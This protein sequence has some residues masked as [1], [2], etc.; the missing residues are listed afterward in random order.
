MNYSTNYTLIG[1]FTSPY[2]R[3]IRL[4]L[5]NLGTYEFKSINYLEQKDGEYL[6][7]IN[8]I[9]QI[10]ILLDGET[11][12]FDSRVIYNYLAKKHHLKPLTIEEENILSA[13]D[14]GLD[15]SINLFSLRRG[16]LDIETCKNAYIDRQKERVPLIFNYLIPWVGHLD[17]KNPDHW[18]FLTMSLYS[19]LYWLGYRNVQDMSAYPE[20]QLF[21]EKFKNAPGVL[22]TTPPTL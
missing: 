18:N 4:L 5:F 6:K 14:A 16:G 20:L 8:P 2:V 3:K 15:T 17:P 9:N 12:I 7:S 19:Y 10:P 1:S 13:I 21:L 22:E 11:K